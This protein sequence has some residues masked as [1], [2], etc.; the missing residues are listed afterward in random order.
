MWETCLRTFHTLMKVFGKSKKQRHM[1]YMYSIKVQPL[2]KCLKKF[3]DLQRASWRSIKIEYR[4][5]C[6]C[7][8]GEL[9]VCGDTAKNAKF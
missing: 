3:D 8:L 2:L 6:L 9:H 5:W 7:C 1:F 4:T